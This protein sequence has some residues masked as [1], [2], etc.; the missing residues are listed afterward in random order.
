MKS[1]LRPVAKIGTDGT[2]TTYST[3]KE[4]A[5]KLEL[6]E[7]SDSNIVKVCR[8]SRQTAAGFRWKFADEIE[9]NHLFENGEEY[10][11]YTF[12]SMYNSLCSHISA[13]VERINLGKV[14]KRR[15]SIHRLIPKYEF[16]PHMLIAKLLHENKN[17]MRINRNIFCNNV[18]DREHFRNIVRVWQLLGVIEEPGNVECGQDGR[19][20]R[21]YKLTEHF[22]DKVLKKDFE[23][24]LYPSSHC[25]M[26][27]RLN[28]YTNFCNCQENRQLSK[29]ARLKSF[30]I[31]WKNDRKSWIE[32]EQS[33]RQ[34]GVYNIERRKFQERRSDMEEKENLASKSDVSWLEPVFS[35]EVIML[36]DRSRQN[37]A[38]IDDLESVGIFTV[39]SILTLNV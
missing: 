9:T 36:P 20:S 37:W 23:E 29:T 17:G 19:E 6:A 15:A 16:L 27:A 21:S 14:R 4:A 5:I 22:A 38:E 28:A 33:W 8:G 10:V 31:K 26:I 39:H 2:V 24:A 1:F 11:M 3:A 13:E 25:L 34:I 7:N 32:N 30:E 18:C 35:E 12:P